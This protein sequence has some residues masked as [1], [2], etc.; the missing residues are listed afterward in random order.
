MKKYE[1]ILK[2]I[3]DKIADSENLIE[4]YREETAKKDAT[5]REL[6]EKTEQLEKDFCEAQ[7]QAFD[8]ADEARKLTDEI[9]ALKKANEALRIENNKLNKF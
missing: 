2:T 9:E 3:N 6:K 5:I 8:Y 7:K 4:Y 1:A